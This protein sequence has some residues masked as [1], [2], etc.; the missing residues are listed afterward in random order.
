MC[1]FDGSCNGS[2]SI[3]FITTP[4]RS[5]YRAVELHRLGVGWCAGKDVV[6]VCDE[7]PTV[8]AEHGFVFAFA[9]PQPLVVDESD[10]ME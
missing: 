4:A 8:R 1:A 3:G 7:R 6:L 2:Y 9:R 5:Q 10:S